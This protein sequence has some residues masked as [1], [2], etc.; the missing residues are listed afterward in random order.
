MLRCDA[1]SLTRDDFVLTADLTLP[2]GAAISVMG[3]SGAGKSTLLS[4][5]G[6]FLDPA[7]GRIL[8]N[9]ADIG[10]LAPAQRPVSTVFQAHNLFP[11]MTAFQNAA[12]GLTLNRRLTGA[13]A[14][15]VHEALSR[16]GLSG[17]Q[18]RRPEALSGG[19]QSRVALAR[20]LLQS[21]PVL[22]LDEPFSALGPAMKAE[23]IG[24]VREVAGRLGALVLLVTHD[25]A[26]ALH[27]GGQTV[28]V[29]DG[30]AHPPADTAAL[31]ADPPPAL[32]A[33]LG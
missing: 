14:T 15:C 21:K 20:V 12:L 11:H 33:Y 31:L 18:D 5:I 19:Q 32:R 22:C 10:R 3:P 17:L 25:P 6:G 13:Q 8:W 2:K 30:V 16:V 27:L 24:L 26:E 1:L 4:A 7:A 29:A 23:M 9:G 28:L